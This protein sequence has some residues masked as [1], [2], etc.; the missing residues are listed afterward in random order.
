[1][2]FENKHM[3]FQAGSV[4]PRKNQL[5]A[6]KMLTPIMRKDRNVVFAYAGGIIDAE[7]KIE[8]DQYIQAQNI[9]D[10]VKYVGELRP[11]ETLN[12]YY[13]SADAF[14]FPS[15]AEAFGLVIIESMAAGTPVL[16][17]RNGILELINVLKNEI[18]LYDTNESFA[19]LIYDKIFDTAEREKL[20]AASRTAVEGKYS[21][22]AVA[23]TY[24]REMQATR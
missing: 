11:G 9:A 23:R 19:E 12:Q 16:A 8:I 6:I 2:G 7:Y 4:C 10:Q 20:S 3:F 24:V 22:N 14:I 15:T 13:A 5:T 1:L 17:D 21:W 18:L